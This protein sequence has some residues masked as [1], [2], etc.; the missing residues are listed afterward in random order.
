MI[1]NHTPSLLVLLKSTV[2]F[3]ETFE[4]YSVIVS[5]KKI[6]QDT[7]GLIEE[8]SSLGGLCIPHAI[9]SLLHLEIRSDD[10][11]REPSI[12]KIFLNL[13]VSCEKFQS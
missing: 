5:S 13:N 11:Q 6:N 8:P 7:I 4:A 10:T 12:D 1:T 3:S 2:L 9:T